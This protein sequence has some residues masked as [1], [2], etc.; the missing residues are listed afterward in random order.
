MC[1]L[2]GAPVFYRERQ[3][4]CGY[5]VGRGFTHKENLVHPHLYKKL[6]SARQERVELLVT[7]CPGCNTALDREQPSLTA[8]SGES[9]NIPVMDLGQLIA[10]ALGVETQ[11]LGF[12]ANSVPV[13][14]VL[15]KLSA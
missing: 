10:L 4:C 1:S 5:A 2:G 14:D 9:F 13:D 15:Q 6:K 3:T 7:V 11:K 8:R 12:E